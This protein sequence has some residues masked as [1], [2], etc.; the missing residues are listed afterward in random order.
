MKPMCC[1]NVQQDVGLDTKGYWNLVTS[2]IL[3]WMQFSWSSTPSRKLQQMATRR[4]SITRFHEVPSWHSLKNVIDVCSGIGALSE[5]VLAAGFDPILS[6]DVNP[7]MT[8]LCAGTASWDCITGDIGDTETV[9]EIWTKARYAK[10]MTAG[11]SCQPFP[12][13]EM[14]W[15]GM[16]HD[17]PVLP[18]FCRRLTS[19]RHRSWFSSVCSLQHP[20][21]LFRVKSRNF[22][23]WQDLTANRSIWNCKT[24]GLREGIGLGGSFHRLLL[25]QLGPQRWDCFTTRWCWSLCFWFEWRYF[26]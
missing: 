18:R 4:S 1:K 24:S 19:F 21:S 11:F 12:S 2:T 20:M 16:T 13:L 5:G 8:D 23:S 15:V 9:H 7:K 26:P 17:R 3:C 25:A 10:T 6:V 14:A 22:S